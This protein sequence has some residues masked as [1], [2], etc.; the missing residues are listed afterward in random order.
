MLDW[1]TILVALLIIAASLYASGR[2]LSRLR[3]FR[4]GR[5]NSSACEAGCGCSGAGKAAVEQKPL[6]S[7]NR[8]PSS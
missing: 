1:Q 4:T 6:T 7:I 5:R 8:A 2:A 3:S